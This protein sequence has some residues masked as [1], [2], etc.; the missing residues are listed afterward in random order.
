[1]SVKIINPTCT[2]LKFRGRTSEYFNEETMS[3]EH[4]ESLT[5]LKRESCKC[6]ECEEIIRDLKNGGGH[7][8]VDCIYWKKFIEPI[9]IEDGKTYTARATWDNDDDCSCYVDEL[10]FSNTDK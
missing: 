2:G 10:T 3:F 1:M 4:K 8:Q 6:E 7:N 5:L 9:E